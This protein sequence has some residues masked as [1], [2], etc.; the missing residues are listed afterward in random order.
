MPPCLALRNI[1]YISRVK[2]NNPGKG[3]APSS[4]PRCSSYCKRNHR[5]AL[6]NSRQLYY[7]YMIICKT[8]FVVGPK[9]EKIFQNEEIHEEICVLLRFICLFPSYKRVC[10]HLVAFVRDVAPDHVNG[11][12]SETLTN[13]CFNGFQF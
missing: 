5:V 2:W 1:R 11:V 8:I 10:F 4:T 12:L 6:D 7:I 3:V 13:S 9:K